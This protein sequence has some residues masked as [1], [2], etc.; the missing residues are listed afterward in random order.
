MAAKGVI[1]T[2]LAGPF[3]ESHFINVHLSPLMTAH[4]RPR[5]RRCVFDA[6]FGRDSLSSNTPGG[7]YLGQPMEYSYPRIEDFRSM[8]LKSGRGCYM[9]KR[10]LSRYFLQI[11]LCPSEYHLVAFVWRCCLFFFTGLMFGLKPVAAADV[12]HTH[13]AFDQQFV[14]AISD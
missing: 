8:I 5:D 2:E 9:W 10:D 11:P 4:K 7:L 14:A 6:S 3:T 12:H 13:T 1:R